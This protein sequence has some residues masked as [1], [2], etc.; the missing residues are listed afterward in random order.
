MLASTRLGVVL[1]ILEEFGVVDDT[2][3]TA[4]TGPG[5]GTKAAM[6]TMTLGPCPVLLSQAVV[7]AMHGLEHR[8]R[9]TRRNSLKVFEELCRLEEDNTLPYIL[10]IQDALLQKKLLKKLVEAGV[11]NPEL[12]A[13]DVN[14]PAA[15]QRELRPTTAIATRP[16]TAAAMKGM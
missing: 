14:N 9:A 16:G 10:S 7:L 1:R 15:A 12:I 11:C 4:S 5:G 6:A 2:G 8:D 13:D 3:A